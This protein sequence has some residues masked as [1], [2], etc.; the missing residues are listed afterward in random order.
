MHTRKWLK[1]IA[2][3]NPLLA[4]IPILCPLKKPEN[5]RFHRVFRG[6]IKWEH[7]PEMV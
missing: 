1:A 7:W 6:G 2:T 5:Q 3:F 4:N